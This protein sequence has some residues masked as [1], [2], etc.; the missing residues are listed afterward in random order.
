MKR[1]A[2]LC[3]LMLLANLLLA[4]GI[5]TNLEEA[6]GEAEYYD[7]PI[8][9]V[10]SGSDWCKP[11]IRLQQQVFNDPK[12]EAFAE[13]NIVMCHIDMPRKKDDQSEEQQKHNTA[14][15]EQ[16]NTDGAFPKLLLLDASGEVIATIDHSQANT[17]AI[18]TAISAHL[19][20]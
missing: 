2:L 18:I 1:T 11:C 8:L 4:G 14:M 19:E 13:V 20:Q 3:L 17:D 10:F 12:F 9:M 7:Q 16:Y 6:K 15:A 5:Y